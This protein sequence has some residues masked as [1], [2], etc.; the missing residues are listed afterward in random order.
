[1]IKLALIVVLFT[2]SS[3]VPYPYSKIIES[4]AN[5]ES[6]IYTSSSGD[7]YLSTSNIRYKFNI[8][9]DIIAPEQC[10]PRPC[11]FP[12]SEYF[13]NLDSWKNSISALD[14]LEEWEKVEIIKYDDYPLFHEL[15]P[16]LKKLEISQ[17]EHKIRVNTREKEEFVYVKADDINPPVF[18][19]LPDDHFAK[20]VYGF[21]VLIVRYKGDLVVRFISGIRKKQ[22]K[23]G[24]TLYVP[25][26][27]QVN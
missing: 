16:T 9:T 27:D 17:M 18:Y 8:E 4:K 2:I 24:M 19:I 23:F 5:P 11:K 3:C 20:S 21:G 1:M 10:M 13:I 6:V 12:Y 26:W 14:S 15:L 22:R 7:V 25:G